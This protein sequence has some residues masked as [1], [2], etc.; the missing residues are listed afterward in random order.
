M[1][2]QGS[3]NVGGGGSGSVLTVTGNTGGAVSPDV[4]GNLTLTGSGGITVTGTPG[5]NSLDISG[6][7]SGI[8]WTDQAANFAAA[9]VSGYFCTSALTATLPASPSQGA[10]IKFITTTSSSVVIQANT[11]QTII[12]STSSSSTAG[13]ATSTASGSSLVLI[14][15]SAETAWRAEGSI[16]NWTTA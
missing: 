7:G 11:G 16:G 10:T 1:S 5:T 15:R 9:D 12:L 4:L 2:Q 6:S 8:T 13:T 14:Y 3:L